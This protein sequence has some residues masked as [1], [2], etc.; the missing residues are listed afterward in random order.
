MTQPRTSWSDANSR[1][2]LRAMFGAAVAAAD[3][4]MVLARYLP[5]PSQGR[6]VVVGFGKAPASSAW[7]RGLAGASGHAANR[8]RSGRQSGQ[9][10]LRSDRAAAAPSKLGGS[11]V[12]PALLRHRAVRG[13]SQ[14]S[15]WIGRGNRAVT[16]NE[17]HSFDRRAVDGPGRG[18][19]MRTNVWDAFG[20]PMCTGATRT[21]VNDLRATR[22]VRNAL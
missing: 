14:L 12:D 6:C 19:G 20:D 4:H 3:P 18:S 8:Q 2:A 21:N 9:D 15:A 11:E 5:E 10:C 17:R 7:A 1:R 22:L 13:G 16:C